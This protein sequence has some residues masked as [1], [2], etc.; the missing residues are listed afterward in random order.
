MSNMSYCRFENTSKDL[1]DCLEAL[2]NPESEM[3]DLS[4]YEKEG[5]RSLIN[6][7]KEITDMEIDVKEIIGHESEEEQED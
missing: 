6:I 4:E 1:K 7:C 3:A 2:K 5:V